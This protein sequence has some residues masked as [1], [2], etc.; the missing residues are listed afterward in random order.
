MNKKNYNVEGYNKPFTVTEDKEKEFLAWAKENNKQYELS[1]EDLGKQSSSAADATVEQTTTASTQEVTQ[2]Q[3]NQQTD[4]DYKPVDGSLE[5]LKDS[6]ESLEKDLKENDYES[7]LNSL[8][9]SIDSIDKNNKSSEY[10]SLAK[11]YN[12]TL[13]DYKY[14]VDTYNSTIEKYNKSLQK[15][16]L[17]AEKEKARFYEE[18][19]QKGLEVIDESK[20]PNALMPDWL[21]SW[22]MSIAEKTLGMIEGTILTFGAQGNID[23]GLME[24]KTE[25]DVIQEALLGDGD[26]SAFTGNALQSIRTVRETLQQFARKEFDADT[27]KELQPIDLLD[28]NNKNFN[29]AKG[30]KLAAEQAVSN[31]YSFIIPAVNPVVGAGFIATSVYGQERQ[32]GLKRY[33]PEELTEEKLKTIKR[34]SALKAGTEFAGEYLGAKLFRSVSGL[35]RSGASEDIVKEYT[36]SI[37]NNALRGIGGGFAGEFLAE[38]LTSLGQDYI[39]EIFY[40][41]EID[42]KKKFRNFVNNGLVGGLLGG[43]LGGGMRATNKVTK[44][45]ITELL[46]SKKWQAKQYNLY[47]KKLKTEDDINNTDDQNTKDA[48]KKRLDLINR[49]IEA[50]QRQLKSVFDNKTD[51]ELQEYA[52]TL[53]E[54]NTQR[55]IAF[56]TTYDKDTRDEA[57]NIILQ[58]QA[59]L[60][61][62]TDGFVNEAFEYRVAEILTAREIIEKRG[63]VRGFGKDLKIKYLRT[64]NDIKKASE[65]TGGEIKTSDGIFID[66]KNK[67]IYINVNVASQTGQTNVLGHELLHYIMSKNFKT[68]NASMKPLVDEFKKYLNESEQGKKI[69]NRIET[70]MKN[71]GYFDSSGKI[72]EDFLEEYFE[73]F[74][75]LVD[76]NQLPMPSDA[77][78]NSLAKSFSD[79]LIG[80]GFK[81]V[82]L[83][84]GKDVFEFIRTYSKN[85]NRKGLL[86]EITKRRITKTKLET[87]IKGVE[88]ATKTITEKQ[89]ASRGRLVD[90]INKMQKGATTQTEFQDRKIFNP[91]YESIINRNGA[92]N[93]YIRSLKMSPEKTQETIDS[94]ADRLINY[95][96]QAKRKTGSKKPITIGEFLMANVGF[97]KLD[98]AKK[99][100]KEGEIKKKTDRID[101]QQEGKRKKDIADTSETVVDEE[102]GDRY[103]KL[104]KVIGLTPE[105]ITKVKESVFS[106]LS[107]RLPNV[108]E[109]DFRKVLQKS[110]K[111]AFFTDIKNLLGKSKSYDNFLKNHF[112]AVYNL[113]PTQTLTQIE[114]SVKDSNRIF[115][116]EVETNI[117]PTV[118]DDYV[119]AGILPKDTNRTSGPSLFEKQPY[120]G[121]D[122]VMAFFR[123]VDMENQLGYKVSGSTFGTRKDGLSL[124]IATELGFDATMEVVQQPEV[125]ERRAQIYGLENQAQIDNDLATI[126]KQI[127]RD[128]RIKFSKS[129]NEQVGN[130][131]KE[132]IQAKNIENVFNLSTG[133]YIGKNKYSELVQNLVL[134]NWANGNIVLDPYGSFVKVINKIPKDVIGGNRGTAFEKHTID[135]GVEAS[136]KHKGFKM[137]IEKVAEGGIPD[138]YANIFGV[139]FNIEVKFGKAR[140]GKTTVNKVNY[141]DL[142]FEIFKYSGGNKEAIDRSVNKALKNGAKKLRQALAKYGIDLV[143]NTSKIPMKYHNIVNGVEKALLKDYS[144]VVDGSYIA[145]TYG[146]KKIPVDLIEIAGAGLYYLQDPHGIAKELGI[147]KLEG[148]F[149]LKTRILSQGY[150]KTK[151]TPTQGYRYGITVE[152]EISAATVSELSPVSLTDPKFFDKL[153]STEAVKLLQAKQRLKK[154]NSTKKSLNNRIKYSKSGKAKG[155]STFDFDETVGVSENFIIAKKG[156][157]KKRIA[158]NEWPFVGQQLENDGW[159]FDFSDF[160]KVTKG[161]PGPLFQKMK[162]Q[163]KKYGPENVFILT[164]RNPQSEQAIHDWLKSNDI[165][166]PRKNV[167]GLG[168]S[169]GQA[170][171]D[172]MLEKF[173]EGY[174]DMY[175]VDDAITNVEAVKNVLEQL[176]IKSKVVQAKIKFSKDASKD[177][178]DMLERTKGVNADKIISQAAARSAGQ[179]KG[180]FEFFIPPSAE[181]F[182]GIIYRFLGKG[183]QGETDLAWFK[184]NLFT[185][186]AKAIRAHD[187][188]RQNMANEWRQLKKDNPKVVEILNKKVKGTDFT[189]D[190][191]VRVYL[192]D[193]AGF[194]IPGLSEQEQKVL[195]DKVNKNKD[196]KNFAEALGVISRRP[197]GYLEPDA[198]WV[199]Q[200]TATDLNTITSRVG[201]RE[202]LQEWIENKDVIFSEQNLNKIQAIYGTS[203]RTALEGILY[204]MEFG[205][206]RTVGKD[207]NVNLFLDWI[208]GSV[209]ATM[210]FN[211]R[212]AILQTISTVNFINMSDNNLFKAAAAFANQPQFWKDFSLL[213]NSDMLK[214]RR[215]GL[216][217]DVN[218]A[219]LTKTFTEGGTTSIDKIRSVIRYMLQKGFLPTQIADSFAIAS[220]GASFYRNRI[221]KYVKEGMSEAK[222]KEQAFLDFQEIAEET[223]QSSRPDLISEQQAGVLGRLILAWQNTPMQMTRLTKKAISD[224]VNN[225][226]DAKAN[227]SKILYYGFIQNII[228]GTLQSGLAFLLFGNDEEEDKVKLKT[229]RVLNGALDTV[230][231]GTGIYG[232]AASTLK[233]TIR[234]WQ[235]ERQ[236]D[237]WKRENLNIAQAMVDL[238]PPMGSKMRKIMN[239]VRTEQYNKGVGEKI[240]FRI[241]NPY[242]S[243]AANVVE[244]GTN[245]PL[246]RLVSKANNLEEA[247]TG[248]HQL[249]QRVAMGAGWSRWSVNVKDEELEKAKAEVKQDKKDKTKANKDKKKQEEKAEK[250]K[251]KK[252]QEEKEK[253]EGIKE[254]RCSGR[255]SNGKRCSIMVKTNA[256]TAKCMYHKTY[257]PN[258]ASDRDGDGVKEYRC[259]ARKANG[260]RCKNRTENKNK[261]C[262]AH[263]K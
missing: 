166:I 195:V 77:A 162:N 179:T 104:R 124:A 11:Q 87:D 84:G 255:K 153:M 163:I 193:K 171:A 53:D 93:N 183:K 35:R 36:R 122:R 205:T 57:K 202:F 180:R 213:F 227:I 214:Q 234:T 204:R 147:P 249:W 129:V 3:N 186:F 209:G 19:R 149:P 138:F 199:V 134:Q 37:T 60:N 97:G 33:K 103:S 145:T 157:E 100:F 66:G 251:V 246:A 184:E 29:V 208:N 243:M 229:E 107:T 30:A 126:A 64:S 248:N 98:A 69:L 27:G 81:S 215:A 150:G 174:N 24:G 45:E 59:K 47:E 46:A 261:K 114:R 13:K 223:Q 125:I 231:R 92:I 61:Q 233:N 257:K 119:A 14:K 116:K 127:D 28:P 212:S 228:F 187:T 155:M 12:A 121:S 198:N 132:T 169:T 9:K 130:L 118:V 67:T 226:G 194:Q 207:A 221:K 203:V 250:A 83:E 161:K 232:A 71:N 70:R 102:T 146:S 159:T 235:K 189:N 90:D 51:K 91:I 252:Q 260:Q 23:K 56:D 110:F 200:T 192:W 26:M 218:A 111:D 182:K 133:K 120:P 62:D 154:A 238:S 167:T 21:K 48:L 32:A 222:A 4:T 6:F 42:A 170:K 220:G 173:A 156:K 254:V 181:D 18:R 79:L 112:E 22:S 244:A 211:M 210:F 86:G 75:D 143:D 206:N 135:I 44:D 31:I 241:E 25:E 88:K 123:G 128:P 8:K 7:T 197:E 117:K 190:T 172:W 152:P 240:G 41:D 2:P 99:L 55:N 113:I 141:K 175:F 89:K 139:P 151:T 239:A 137:L 140:A 136:K 115:V 40:G 76:K 217:T 16:Q 165:N 131:I 262:Y 68:D 78:G 216:Q 237:A 73:M 191:A 63:G 164:A 38:G 253:K 247:V 185:P 95:D 49:N 256:K 74:S 245:I 39:D 65:D 85:V 72:K 144:E 219:E 96:P 259:V 10:N 82:K 43:S 101:Q 34:A 201:R 263:N 242:L 188:Y 15:N 236:K 108:K 168:N 160:N 1:S 5:S 178:N 176:D 94:V 52:K 148:K 225:R 196:L 230:L 20:T 58:L 50:N 106:I 142:T 54:I 258:E 158:S 177:F 224:L 17:S 109:K 80:L 105:L